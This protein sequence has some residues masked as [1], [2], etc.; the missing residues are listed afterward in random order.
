MHSIFILKIQCSNYGQLELDYN[1]V[2]QSEAR[3]GNFLNIIFAGFT[4]QMFEERPCLGSVTCQGSEESKLYT[5]SM[6]RSSSCLTGYIS[7]Y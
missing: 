1:S 2:Q 5:I 4:R 3:L 6:G 7:F